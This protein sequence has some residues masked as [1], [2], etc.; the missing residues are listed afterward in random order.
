MILTLL[1]LLHSAPW[2]RGNGNPPVHLQLGIHSSIHDLSP[3]LGIEAGSEHFGG[4]ME[5][6]IRPF[7]WKSMEQESSTSW[8]Q[9][10][11]LRY[12]FVLGCHAL[13]GS[14]ELG[15]V[16]MAGVELVGGDAAGSNHS[17]SGEANPWAGLGIA[18]AGH[19]RI[20]LRLGWNDGVLGK[21]RVDWVATL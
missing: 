2:L 18:F 20:D 12:G 7:Y 21:A 19:H 13:I 17:P 14:R 6:W 9:Y 1:L 5:G 15:L 16:P 3:L 4:S 11:I 10:R 8:V